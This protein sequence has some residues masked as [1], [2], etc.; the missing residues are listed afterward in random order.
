MAVQEI[1]RR[2]VLSALLGAGV[3]IVPSAAVVADAATPTSG[4]VT[5]AATTVSWSAGPFVTPNTT[6]AATGEPLCTLPTMCDDFAL[7][8]STPPGYGTGHQL[9]ISVSWPVAAADF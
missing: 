9:S 2:A 6:G 5:D 4:T 3:L 1:H 7:H 8:V